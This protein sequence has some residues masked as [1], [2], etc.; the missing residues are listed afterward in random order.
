MSKLRKVEWSRTPPDSEGYWLGGEW[1][2]NKFYRLVIE[3]Q[4]AGNSFEWSFGDGLTW[5]SVDEYPYYWWCPIV[6]PANPPLPL[7]RIV[8]KRFPRR[9]RKGK[10][11]GSN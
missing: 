5:N 4:R 11:P 9:T 8:R 3:V 2:R 6:I 10:K 7:K 1:H